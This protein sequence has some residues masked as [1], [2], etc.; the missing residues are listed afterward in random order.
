MKHWLSP[1]L[2]VKVGRQLEKLIYFMTLVLTSIPKIIETM[3]H[4]DWKR[5]Q[6]EARTIKSHFEHPNRQ[7]EGQNSTT[8]E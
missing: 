5:N 4:T 1:L 3:I 7:P 2:F 6:S 8:D